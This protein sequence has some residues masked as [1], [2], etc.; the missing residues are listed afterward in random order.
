VAVALASD[1]G[2]TAIN[3]Y[4]PALSPSKHGIAGPVRPRR[5]QAA[6]SCVYIN[7]KDASWA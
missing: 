2:R 1:P 6:G 3:A 7:R 4:H 5:A